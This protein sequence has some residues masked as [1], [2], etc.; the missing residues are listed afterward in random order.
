MQK[1]AEARLA[2]DRQWS[3]DARARLDAAQ[4]RL[5]DAFAKLAQAR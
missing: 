4:K 3:K 1:A 5:D 2:S